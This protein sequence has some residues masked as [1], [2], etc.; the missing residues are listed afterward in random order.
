MFCKFVED[1]EIRNC[2]Q[3]MDP[4]CSVV[5]ENHCGSNFCES[6]DVLCFVNLYVTHAGFEI[7]F[8]KIKIVSKENYIS[9]RNIILFEAQ[10]L[11]K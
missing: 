7:L 9:R 4:L 3:V 6:Q 1:A 8:Q 5:C 2:F 11:N 10:Y